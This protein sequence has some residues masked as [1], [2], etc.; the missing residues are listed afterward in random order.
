MG[1][2]SKPVADLRAEIKKLMFASDKTPIVV[3]EEQARF[4]MI[5]SAF[6]NYE[7]V[8]SVTHRELGRGVWRREGWGS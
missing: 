1:F 8:V 3:V 2:Q 6:H 4:I 5:M 7:K